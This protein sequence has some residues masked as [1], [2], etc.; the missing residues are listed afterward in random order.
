[1]VAGERIGAQGG[2][3]SVPRPRTPGHAAPSALLWHALPPLSL[4]VDGAVRLQQDEAE[5]PDVVFL[6]IF[7][8]FLDHDFTSSALLSP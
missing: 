7:A 4:W 3:W 6:S 1:M 2:Q 8:V 5:L